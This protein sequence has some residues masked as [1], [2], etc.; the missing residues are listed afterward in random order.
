MYFQARDDVRIAVNSQT[1]VN[2]KRYSYH[3]GTIINGRIILSKGIGRV[4]FGFDLFIIANPTFIFTTSI[5]NEFGKLTARYAKGQWSVIIRNLKDQSFNVSSVLR[6]DMI[7]DLV[8]TVEKANPELLDE[9][10]LYIFDNRL[11]S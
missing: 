9:L 8:D 10:E 5:K 7:N 3:L 1:R 4:R 2:L 11:L 6:N